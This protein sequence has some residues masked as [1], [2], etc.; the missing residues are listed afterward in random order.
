MK[1]LNLATKDEVAGLKAKI[2]ELSAK[3]GHGPSIEDDGR[4]DV[5]RTFSEL[6]MR[7]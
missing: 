1:R 2:D 6:E 7:L 4:P 5:R 3:V